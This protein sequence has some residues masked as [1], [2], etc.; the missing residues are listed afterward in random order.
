M[1]RPNLTQELVDEY[2]RL[3][4]D[5]GSDNIRDW[6]LLHMKVKR[7]ILDMLNSYGS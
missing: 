7:F 2:F 4:E 3:S 1:I 5:D 6:A